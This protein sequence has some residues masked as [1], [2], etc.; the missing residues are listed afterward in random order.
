[1]RFWTAC[2]VYIIIISTCLILQ[3]YSPS[4]GEISISVLQYNVVI[5]VYAFISAIFAALFIYYIVK[6]FIL[7]ASGL[8]I[9]STATR[10]RIITEELAEAII[11]DN[12]SSSKLANLNVPDRLNIIRTAIILRHRSDGFEITAETGV[13]GIDI[14]IMRYRLRRLLNQGDVYKGVQL[15]M[16]IIGRYDKYIPVVQN[17]ILMIAELARKNAIDFKFDPRKFKYNL[18]QSFTE[19]YYISLALTDFHLSPNNDS[20]MKILER[21]LSDFPAN[22]QIASKLLDVISEQKF[23]NF[24]KKIVNIVTKTFSLRPDRSLAY[25]LIKINRKD[26]LELAQKI[27]SSIPDTNIEKIWFMLIISTK[28]N[29]VSKAKEIIKHHF[30]DYDQLSNLS[31]FYI[32]NYEVLSSDNEIVEIMRRM[33]SEN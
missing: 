20:K 3:S 5:E 22:I 8:S 15:A 28:L 26:I 12:H 6:S 11:T 1:M 23:E 21:A 33:Y 4:I 27:T 17:E 32:Q 14:H 16:D 9:W 24:E 31:S 7:W 29:L 19:E 18:S 2:L 13:L 25:H 30:K 10:E